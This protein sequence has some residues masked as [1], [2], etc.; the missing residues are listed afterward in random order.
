[1]RIDVFRQFDELWGQHTIDIFTRHYNTKLLRFN[2]R[3]HQ[4]GTEDVDA[5]A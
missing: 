5:F 3:F 2:Y 1:M 4:P